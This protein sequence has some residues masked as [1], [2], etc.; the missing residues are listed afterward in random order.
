MSAE[1][2]T[3][4]IE[5]L[6]CADEEALLRK[7][8]GAVQGINELRFN[9]VGRRLTVE[10]TC[11]QAAIGDAIRGAGFTPRL[12]FENVAVGN[13]FQRHEKAI[14]T[15]ISALFLLTG[16]LNDTV[17]GIRPCPRSSSQFRRWPVGGALHGKGGKR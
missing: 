14:S 13:V 9:L 7:A 8:L 16:I 6:C 12:H 1:S 15:G 11:G 17:P 2:T 3:Y 10:H 4:Y 5:G